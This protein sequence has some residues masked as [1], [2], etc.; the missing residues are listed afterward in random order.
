M[1]GAQR[2]IARRFSG[3]IGRF[4]AALKGQG[5]SLEQVQ[6]AK[7]TAAFDAKWGRSIIN[8]DLFTAPVYRG[9]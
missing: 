5:K 9:V 4:A 6:A 1:R 3:L 7:P 2:T 8:G